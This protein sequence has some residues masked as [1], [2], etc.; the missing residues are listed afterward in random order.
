MN[1]NEDKYTQMQ[2]KL[3]EGLQILSEAS[4]ED[5]YKLNTALIKIH[6][7]LEDFVRIGVAQK[8]PHLRATVEDVKQTAWNDL[9]A[10]GKQYLGFSESDARLISALNRQRQ[11]VAHGNNYPG[12]RAE[13]AEYGAFVE[14]WCNPGEALSEHSLPKQ[15]MEISEAHQSAS[16]PPP[17]Y[18]AYP[19]QPWYRST[20]FL[21][22]TFFLLP[23]VWAILIIT[24]RSQGKPVTAFAYTVLIVIFLCGIGLVS[25]SLFMAD[26]FTGIFNQLNIPFVP[27]R[28]T[29]TTASPPGN[30]VP[31]GG[32]TV[33]PVQ[34][35]VAASTEVVCRIVW[36]E[37]PQDLA[38]KTRSTVWEEIV[39][40]QVEG[41][42]MTHREFYDLVVEH[43][44]ELV[45]DD[46]EFKRGKTYLLPECQ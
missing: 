41:S 23:P 34:P 13:L 37:H 17:A 4:N 18:S 3:R 31:S 8:A 40:F 12:S 2:A 20:L 9:I 25:S 42:G 39:K 22:L 32:I 45:A 21:V 10:Y 11:D 28:I 36:V 24:D 38:R 33:T 26:T 46:Y 5:K 1:T 15:G 44:P 30:E 43:N 35:T 16:M 27:T 19:P 29:Q 14:R 6:S 7:A